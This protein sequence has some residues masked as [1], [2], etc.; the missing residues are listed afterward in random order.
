MTYRRLTIAGAAVLLAGAVASTVALA[1]DRRVDIVN[2]TG[3]V[4]THFYASNSG[5]DSWEEDILGRDT[6]ADGETVQVDINDGTGACKFDFKAVFENGSS[7]VRNNIDVCK[8]S[9][10]TYNQ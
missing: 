4:M 6:L 2:K 8:I 5:T 1:A 10:F 7:L 3:L 9:T